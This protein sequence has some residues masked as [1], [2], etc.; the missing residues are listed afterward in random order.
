MPEK[1]TNP[2]PE[3][4]E[5]GAYLYALAVIA[6][7]VIMDAVDSLEMKPHEKAVALLLSTGCVLSRLQ[8]AAAA[9]E[10]FESA[11]EFRDARQAL[12]RI[13]ADVA[14]SAIEAG[15]TGVP[16]DVDAYAKEIAEVAA[17]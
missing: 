4:A 17:V 5:R 2:N 1:E 13:C 12:N 10:D 8:K 9:G 11:Q 7:P 3:N 14:D 6:D 16:Y 15:I